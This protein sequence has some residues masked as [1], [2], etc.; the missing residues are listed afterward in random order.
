MHRLLETQ[1]GNHQGPIPTSID[2]K[3]TII[4]IQGEI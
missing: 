4:A 1:S 3:D 2:D